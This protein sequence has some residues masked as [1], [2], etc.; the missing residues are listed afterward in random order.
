MARGS[1]ISWLVVEVA[2]PVGTAR[3]FSRGLGVRSEGSL[4]LRGS[5]MIW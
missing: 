3:G 4:I 2:P 5:Y 1:V